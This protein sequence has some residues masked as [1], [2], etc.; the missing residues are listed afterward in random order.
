[1]TE[2]EL[3][4]YFNDCTGTL[5]YL[6]DDADD[7]A[8]YRCRECDD[9]FPQEEIEYWADQDGPVSKLAKVLLEGYYTG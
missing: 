4:C 9:E 8:L 7:P 2:N 3:D 5:E 1:M 6:G